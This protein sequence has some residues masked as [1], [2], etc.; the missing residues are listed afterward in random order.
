MA[1]YSDREYGYTISTH[2]TIYIPIGFT[3]FFTHFTD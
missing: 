1:N 2:F 3:I